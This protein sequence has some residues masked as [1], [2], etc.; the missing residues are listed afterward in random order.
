M[1]T[2]LSFLLITTGCSVDA[3]DEEQPIERG[4]EATVSPSAIYELEAKHS[5][6]VLDISAASTADGANVQQ[7]VRNG[8]AAQRFRFEPTAAGFYVIRALASGKVLDVQDRR[9][10]EGANVQQWTHWGGENQQWRVEDAG[11]GYVYV[12]ARHSGMYLDVAWA[13]K[14]D[15]A[16]VAQ[17]RHYGSDAQKWKLIAVSSGAPSAPSGGSLPTRL[18]ITSQCAEPVWIAHSDN[19]G[20]P[21]NVRLTKG[22]SYDY[23]IPDSGLSATRFWPKTGCDGGGHNCRIGDNGEGGG[24]PCPSTGCQPPVDSK[25]EATFAARGASAQT[26]YNLSQVDGYTLSFK[27]IP[28]GPGAESGSC[29]S[30]DC[31]ALSLD[32]CPSGDDLSGG[33]RFPAYAREDLRVRDASGRVI[34]CMAPC[35]KWNYPA[36]WGRG[37]SEAVEPGLHLCCP[38]PIDPTSGGCSIDKSCMTS[39]ACSNPGDPL[40]VVHTDYVAEMRSMCPSAYSYAYDDAA[41]LHACSSQTQFEVIFC[42]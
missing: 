24:K 10:N 28:R 11:G 21:Q 23:R 17:V 34:A 27:V 19:V 4:G 36:P 40:S 37:Q 3:L 8:T 2:L 5:G 9:T 39:E 12:R 31:T 6:K 33:G 38:T 32:R 22:Q 25:F 14:H 7:W 13:A 26:W 16:N 15:G 30:S 42:P 29:V 1:R 20:D 41:G 35:K 18:R